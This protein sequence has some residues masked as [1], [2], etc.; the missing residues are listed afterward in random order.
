MNKKEPKKEVKDKPKK[1][2]KGLLIAL[3]VLAVVLLLAT[4]GIFVMRYLNNKKAQEE[5]LIVKTEE[6]SGYVLNTYLSMLQSFN[7]DLLKTSGVVLTSDV[8]NET[9]FINGSDMMQE[10][11]K[12]VCSSVTFS[13]LDMVVRLTEDVVPV[14]FT[15]QSIDYSALSQ[16]IDTGK[17]QE[18]MSAQGYSS[19]D[20]DI[21]YKVQN[22]FFEY[23]FSLE[24]V[25]MI[26][27]QLTLNLVKQQ[28]A[29]Y[30]IPY[31]VYAIESDSVIDE[32]LFGSSFFHDLQDE[33]A[34]V[35]IG[36]TGFKAEAYIDQEEKENPEY[37]A[38]LEQLNAEIAKYP[39][40]SN[41]S[42]CLYEP[43]YLRDENN[44]IVKDENGNKVV[45]FYVLFEPNSS[46]KKVRD[47]TSP[48][49]YKYIP[50]PEHTVMVD[51][52][53]ERQVED[54]WVAGSVFKYNFTGYSYVLDNGLS[55]RAGD[56]SAENPAAEDTDVFSKVITSEGV[57]DINISLK[58]SYVGVDAIQYAI[59]HS[60]KNRGLD[61]SSVVK[62]VVCE[63]SVTN[64]SD[65]VITFTPDMVLVDSTGSKLS[66]TGTIY[67]LT[68][69][70]T[71]Q[72]G[73]TVVVQD[74]ASSTDLQRYQVAW[75]KSFDT[76][77]PIQYFN[78]VK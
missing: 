65:S 51:V 33:F 63:F 29:G 48:Y 31:P 19:S 45:N 57:F 55:I 64:L 70:Y 60:E 23:V 43:Y 68:E 9:E 22:V 3:I 36:W 2:K 15:L 74:W 58:K 71:L 12:W 10:Y 69:L 49:G 53:K 75:G 17:V 50:E 62:I 41:T 37:T 14:E 73:E 40:W 46:G 30:E 26:E 34:K 27:T 6:T 44:K 38:W 16:S 72:P 47:K 56:G 25:P 54:P 67:G 59:D 42:K 28:D 66:R 13:D 18:I 24:E 78:V 39:T 1:S 5:A 77:I 52:E 76:S 35:V 8:A 21:C 61:S 4:V 20:I 32:V 7:A 11:L